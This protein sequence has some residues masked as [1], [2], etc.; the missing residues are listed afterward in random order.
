MMVRHLLI[1]RAR[2]APLESV[3]ELRFTP[4]GIVSGVPCQPLRQVLILPT[5]TLEEFGLRPGEL[6]ENIVVDWPHLHDL[7]SGSVI[8][9][10]DARIRL[11]FHCE[12]CGRVSEYVN[13]GKV[14]HKRG[15]L[16]SFLNAG[17]IRLGDSVAR[18][19]KRRE[20]IPYVVKDRI[21]W[22]LQKR[23]CPIS[24]RDLLWEVGLSSA[25]ARALPGLLRSLPSKLEVLVEFKEKSNR[26]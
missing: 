16:G 26:V 15:Y 2:G 19:L 12:P 1:K 18:S 24:A 9:I 5:T 17:Y 10:G 3:R 6:R 8:R 21:A 13:P 4:D 7:P 22:F 14:L 20:P 23:N 11:T 25:Y